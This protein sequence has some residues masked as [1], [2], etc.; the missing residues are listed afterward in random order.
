MQHQEPEQ[1]VIVVRV[2]PFRDPKLKDGENYCRFFLWWH[3]PTEP[4]IDIAKS[5]D[6]AGVIKYLGSKRRLV[7]KLVELVA[8]EAPNARTFLDVFS[9]TA[10][11]GM[12]MKQHGLRV[13]SNDHNAYA[14]TLARPDVIEC[15]A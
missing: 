11:V 1:E 14:H 4:N 7:G 12:A 5:C 8:H 2:P 10:R 9:G 15:T 13:I 3:P 6:G